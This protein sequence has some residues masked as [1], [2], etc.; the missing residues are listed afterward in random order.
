MGN[1]TNMV[2]PWSSYLVFKESEFKILQGFLDPVPSTNIYFFVKQKNVQ[3]LET[4]KFG[5]TDLFYFP[6]FK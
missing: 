4:L 1:G 5:N 6:S 3:V 2:P